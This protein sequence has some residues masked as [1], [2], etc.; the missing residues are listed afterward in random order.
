MSPSKNHIIQL[1]TTIVALSLPLTYESTR[2]FNPFKDEFDSLALEPLNTQVCMHNGSSIIR[3]LTSHSLSS[4]ETTVC[5]KWWDVALF[6]SSSSSNRLY[7]SMLSIIYLTW[8]KKSYL[9]S[10]TP[11]ATIVLSSTMTIVSSA[12]N[13]L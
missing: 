6:K 11:R 1:F 9:S 10:K 7:S 13:C 3:S 12:Q 2:V 5:C 4:L 8:H